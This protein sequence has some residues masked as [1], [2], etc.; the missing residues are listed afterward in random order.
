MALTETEKQEFLDRIAALL[1]DD[2]LT[3]EDRN[4]ILWYCMSVC[5]RELRAN[6]AKEG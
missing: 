5:V 4:H 6:N 1:R 2:I 3:V